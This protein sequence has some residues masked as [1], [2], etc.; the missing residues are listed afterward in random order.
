MPIDK[1]K[2]KKALDQFQ[3]DDF[4][5][6]KETLQPEI[7]KAKEEFLQKKLDLKDPITPTEKGDDDKGE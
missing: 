7:K 3:D 2:V 5:G 6:A 1:E 4:V